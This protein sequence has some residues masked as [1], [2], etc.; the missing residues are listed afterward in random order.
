MGMVIAFVFTLTLLPALLTVLRP[1]GEPERLGYAFLAPVDAFLGRH[2]I[3][4]VAATLAVVLA[5]IA[6]AGLAA[7][8]IST[9]CTCR[10]RTARRCGP[11]ASWAATRRPGVAAV[12]VAAPS[13]DCGA[14][15]W[16]KRLAALPQVQGTRTVDVLIPA[17]Q[18]PKLAA[19]Q[20]AAATLL[21]ALSPAQTRPAPT[22]AETVDRHPAGGVRP[23]RR[24][25]PGP[26]EAAA[27]ALG[28]C[29]RRSCAPRWPTRWCGRCRWTWISCAPRCSR[30]R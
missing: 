16:R 18:A 28:G 7:V 17:D 19:I 5:G 25:R 30:R 1:P 20:R 10:T 22:D 8:S 23:G 11:I 4:V 21:P 27:A 2:R 9:R 29:R 24:R 14:R 15:R 26:A 13:L 6:A 3:A 12:D